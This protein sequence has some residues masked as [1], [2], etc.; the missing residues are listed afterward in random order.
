V[1]SSARLK[2]I[3]SRA[4]ASAHDCLRDSILIDEINFTRTRAGAIDEASQRSNHSP[5]I[6]FKQRI[7]FQRYSR[8][9]IFFK[10]A[11]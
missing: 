3:Q 5:K 8:C 11:R 1:L 2:K 10:R 4:R 7:F 6:F 9:A